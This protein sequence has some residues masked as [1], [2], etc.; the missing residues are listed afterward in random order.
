LVA[1]I[2]GSV[3][4][5]AVLDKTAEMIARRRGER[6]SF[7]MAR[8]IYRWLNPAAVW[9]IERLG[10]GAHNGVLYH[11]GRSSGREYA[12]PLCMVP[13]PEGYI[14]P[15]SFGPKTDW[16]K[17]LKVTPESRVVFDNKSHE[18]LAEVISLDQAIEHAGG[19]PGCRCWV[20]GNVETMVLLRA[21]DSSDSR[22]PA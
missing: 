12:T 4:I 15:A 11:T 10:V 17:N 5:L 6:R 18:T 8:R 19:T 14:V 16:L 3:S 2:L 9:A 21:A 22:R 13:T 1:V 20:D 7:P